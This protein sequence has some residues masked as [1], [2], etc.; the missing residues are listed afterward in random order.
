MLTN[1]CVIPFSACYSKERSLNLDL[2][3]DLV[4]TDFL[5]GRDLHNELTQ[6]AKR[7]LW[8]R[9]SCISDNAQEDA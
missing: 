7:T 1:A 9:G 2:S 4:D 8:E 5:S 6:L 3:V